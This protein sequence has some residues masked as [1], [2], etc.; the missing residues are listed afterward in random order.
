MKMFL[1]EIILAFGQKFLWFLSTLKQNLQNSESTNHS[2]AG[3]KR[4]KVRCE[5]KILLH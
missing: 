3:A 5:E 2:D 1:L 4:P